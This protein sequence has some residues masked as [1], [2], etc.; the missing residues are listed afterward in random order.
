MMSDK[1]ILLGISKSEKRDETVLAL[2][3]S[4]GH[5]LGEREARKFIEWMLNRK[6][7]G[8]SFVA[9]TG[10]RVIKGVGEY[11]IA[12]VEGNRFCIIHLETGNRFRDPVYLEEGAS[13]LTEEQLTEIA[14]TYTKIIKTE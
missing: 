11:L 9:K 7:R 14:G 2:I 6:L 4:L 10:D 13:G 8:S 3:Q 12:Q 5:T 1:E